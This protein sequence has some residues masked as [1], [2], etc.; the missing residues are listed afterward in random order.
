MTPI[1][2]TIGV[3]TE[4]AGLKANL[5]A[6]IAAEQLDQVNSILIGSGYNV[7]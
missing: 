6:A 4:D 2:Y 1:T 3:Q 7:G 5:M